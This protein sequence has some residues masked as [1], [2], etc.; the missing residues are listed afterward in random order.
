MIEIQRKAQKDDIVQRYVEVTRLCFSLVFDN[1][2][3]VFRFAHSSVQEYLIQHN[4]RYKDINESYA[5]VA[6]SLISILLQTSK[7]YAGYYAKYFDYENEAES[8]VKG[9]FRSL[10]NRA[11]STDSDLL[12]FEIQ[13]GAVTTPT[14]SA[15]LAAE[16]VWATCVAYSEGHLQN[17]HLGALETELLSRT[18][19]QPWYLVRPAIFFSACNAG[20]KDFVQAC[21]EAHSGLLRVALQYPTISTALINTTISEFDVPDEV[22]ELLEL[23]VDNGADTGFFLS[24]HCYSLL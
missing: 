4:P 21:L 1:A 10:P 15:I 9:Q 2:T 6:E 11:D 20:R 7:Q 22:F 8:A 3:G 24:C 12:S 17:L 13:W 14:E 19:E 16:R 23:L 18:I 5:L